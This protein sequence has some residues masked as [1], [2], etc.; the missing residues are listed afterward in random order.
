MAD[1]DSIL[2][3]SAAAAK[4][5]SVPAEGKVFR[6]PEATSDHLPQNLLQAFQKPQLFLEGPT[7]ERKIAEEHFVIVGAGVAGLT[8][9]LLL[10]Q[11]GHR[12]TILESSQR[13]G[14]RVFT[15][16][17]DG[18]YVDMGAMRFPPHHHLLHGVLA[19]LE[20]PVTPFAHLHKRQGSYFF[21]NNKY[22]PAGSL[23][24]GP[25]AEID[26]EALLEVYS[27][28]N[29][30]DSPVLRRSSTGSLLSPFTIF[31]E[32][33]ET[34]PNLDI[35]TRQFFRQEIAKRELPEGLIRFWGT[36]E[37]L[38]PYL[39]QSVLYMTDSSPSLLKEEDA[40]EEEKEYMEIVNGSSV[41]PHTMLEKVQQFGDKFKL[42]LGARVV[43]VEQDDNKVWLTFSGPEL[44]SSEVEGDKAILTPPT[45]AQRTIQHVPPLPYG[46]TLAIQSL[47]YMGSVKIGLFFTRAFWAEQNKAPII[48]FA[49]MG[50]GLSGGTGVTDSLLS[51]TYYPSNSEHGPCLV[52][53]YTWEKDSD[54]WAAMSDEE[55][56]ETA[57]D[58]LTVVHGP[59][60]RETYK[61]GVVKRWQDD[62]H[63]RG[64]FVVW[65][66]NQQE[67]DM[68]A[69]QQPHGRVSFAGEFANKV[70]QGWIN[71]ALTSAIRNLLNM[72]PTA[73]EEKFGEAE[74]KA[75]Q[76]KP[77]RVQKLG[78]FFEE[79]SGEVEKKAFSNARLEKLKRAQK[80]RRF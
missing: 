16:Y 42:V 28:F 9:A 24:A 23:G 27:L 73:F 19:H 10:L 37:I 30:F 50:N 21:I 72:W 54:V 20:I 48:R 74:R 4:D 7:A 15:H 52:A 79:K 5:E 17:D 39:D 80:L 14:G 65:D 40:E 22:Y 60:V 61:A 31:D 46:K 64:A 68:E 70:H 25:D 34:E 77:N 18:W 51:Q 62:N 59:V 12:V 53:S 71:A 36:L 47:H 56:I 43:K 44:T 76:E 57:I 8:S 45:S 67:Q 66:V 33:L 69:L 13:V 35:P 58:L 63:E 78:R 41:L 26:E 29:I 2:P 11:A 6:A 75:R 1:A 49:P 3:P 32:I 55:A 38:R